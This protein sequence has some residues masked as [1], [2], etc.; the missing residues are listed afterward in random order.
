MKK[1]ILTAAIGFLGTIAFGQTNFNEVKIDSY[2][3]TDGTFVEEHLR[4]SPDNSFNNNWT[5]A[6]NT[7]PH[8]GVVG[9]KT[10]PSTSSSNYYYKPST[11]SFYTPIYYYS[12]TNKT[13]RRK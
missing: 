5:T 3:K 2:L 10:F 7:N 13:R 4:T 11:P 6:G 12:S 9:T 8:T 1:L